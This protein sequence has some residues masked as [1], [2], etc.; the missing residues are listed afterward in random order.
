MVGNAYQQIHTYVFGENIK[1]IILII[2]V[3]NL[4]LASKDINIFENINTKL[5]KAFKMIDLGTISN[6]LGIKVQREGETGKICLSQQ[7]YV[8]E[9]CEKFDMQNAKTVPTPIESNVK[10]AKEIHPK[11]K[12]E[13][14]EMEKRPYRELVGGLIYLTNA[15]RKLHDQIS[16]SLLAC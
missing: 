5:K 4:I 2:Y 7:K 1:R 10:I 8:N 15:T 13:K 9:L 16:H 6:I 12:D 14:R 11:T 3:D